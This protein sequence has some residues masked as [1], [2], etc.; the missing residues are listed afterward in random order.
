MLS[1]SVNPAVFLA[2][3]LLLSGCVAPVPTFRPVGTAAQLEPFEGSTLRVAIAAT[4]QTQAVASE[5]THYQVTVKVDTLTM[6]RTVPVSETAAW[7]DLPNLPAGA[8]LV[9]V[10]A[11]QGAS[12]VGSGTSAV[13]LRIGARSYVQ[14]SVPLTCAGSLDLPLAVPLAYIPFNDPSFVDGSAIVSTPSSTPSNW[15]LVRDF[16]TSTNPDGAW[17]YG[18]KMDLLSPLVLNDVFCEVGDNPGA[19]EWISSSQDGGSQVWKNLTSST[20]FGIAPGQVSMHPDYQGHVAVVRWTAP[21]NMKVRVNAYFGAGDSGAMDYMIYHDQS[22][23]FQQ[24]SCTS[25]AVTD[26]DIM[27]LAGSNLDFEI[28]NGYYYGN[29]PI[30]A[31]ISRITE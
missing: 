13:H 29:T 5:I 28:N 11:Y 3:V 25:D 9:T 12:K 7:V 21:E 24:A 14:V 31:I 6:T 4:R 20:R 16:S 1:R 27:V 10:E 23:I 30:A 22:I 2:G 17:S 15:D 19:I 8:G 18:W 26:F